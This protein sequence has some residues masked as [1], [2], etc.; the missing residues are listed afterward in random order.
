MSDDINQASQVRR[1]AAGE[2]YGLWCGQ[3]VYLTAAGCAFSTPGK[4][5]GRSWLAA[6]SLVAS[7]AITPGNG[8]PD[9]LRLRGIRNSNGL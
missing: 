6:I 5:P 8:M 9:S 7:F 1:L 4:L 3:G 2:F